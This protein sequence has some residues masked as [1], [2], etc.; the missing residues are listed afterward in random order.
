MIPCQKSGPAPEPSQ[1]VSEDYILGPVIEVWEPASNRWRRVGS[2]IQRHELPAQPKKAVEPELLPPW[3]ETLPH[4]PIEALRFAIK[5]EADYPTR[6]ELYERLQAIENAARLL[7]KELPDLRMRQLL[8]DGDQTFL[9]QNETYHGL[10]D[11]AER[12]ARVRAQNPPRQGRGK[13]Y[14]ENARGPNERVLCALI[15]MIAWKRHNG[16][17]PKN[18]ATMH[19]ACAALWRTAGGKNIALGWADGRPESVIAWRAHMGTAANFRPPQHPAGRIIE[20][21]FDP[22][23]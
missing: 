13:L 15:V 19:E 11:I 18:N 20:N 16:D 1:S 2:A 12:A 23:F 14:P 22:V 7:R 5:K 10:H 21:F 3:L 9:N 8:L 6:P 17:W 4:G